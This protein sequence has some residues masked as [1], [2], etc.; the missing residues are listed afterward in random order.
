MPPPPG[1]KPDKLLIK[2][3]II[4]HGL[5]GRSS[6]RVSLWVDR[7]MNATMGGAPF[8]PAFA[9]RPIFP[10]LPAG[11]GGDVHQTSLVARQL[12]G[13]CCIDY[14]WLNLL[15][16]SALQMIVLLVLAMRRTDTVFGWPFP[17]MR[18]PRPG[19][20]PEHW[21]YNYPPGGPKE[22]GKMLDAEPPKY[23]KTLDPSR[24]R[25]D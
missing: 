10:A 20:P 15:T 5:L 8:L 13:A 16:M 2:A 18:E 22:D 1:Q 9:V 4:E 19:E 7:G 14:N 3:T 17:W 24:Q 21:L 23:S 12:Q 11:P 6:S 25:G